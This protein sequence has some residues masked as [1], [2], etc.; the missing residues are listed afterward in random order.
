MKKLLLLSLF[1]AAQAYSLSPSQAQRFKRIISERNCWS[2]RTT[3][4]DDIDTQ[5]N[6]T[7]QAVQNGLQTIRALGVTVFKSV[8]KAA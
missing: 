5:L 8:E 3:I 1:F 6:A 4:L 7:K 2:G